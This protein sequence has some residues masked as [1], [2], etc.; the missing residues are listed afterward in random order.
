MT[1]RTELLFKPL[2]IASNLLRKVFGEWDWEPAPWMQALGARIR[3]RPWAWA[4]GTL[5]LLGVAYGA[6]WWVH[7][8]KPVDPEAI[9]FTVS[10]VNIT[11]YTQ[12]PPAV[13]PLTV[14]FSASVAPIALVDKP[15]TGISMDPALDGVWTWVGDRQLVFR[16]A[17]DWTVGQHYK[18][19]FD[20]IN[21]FAPKLR[22]AERQFEFDT[23]TFAATLNSSEFYQD[24]EDPKLKK[25]VYEIGFSHPVDVASFEQRVSLA[26][27]NGAGKKLTAPGIS[28][29]YDERKLKAYV[30]SQ[31]LEVPED[32]G[33]LAMTVEPGSK[34]TLG[35]PAVDQPISAAV[36]LPSLYSVAVNEIAPTLVDNDRFE[37]E[38][39]LVF[40]FNNT[41]RD[42][43]VA[44]GI[45]VYEL[46]ETNPKLK[47]DQQTSP[48][49]WST[50]EV[51]AGVLKASTQ[52]KLIAVPTE[53]EYIETHSFRYQATA[54]RKLYVRV[55]R[56]LKSFGGFMLGK[57]YTQ[58]IE[59]PAYPELL[60]FVGDGAL[61]SLK[62]ERRVTVAARNVAGLKVEIARVLPDQLQHLVKYNNGSFGVPSLYN[63]SSDSIVERFRRRVA[64]NNSD[65][66]KTQYEGIDLGEF[67]R[68]DKH[69]VF[70]LSLYKDDPAQDDAEDAASEGE[71]EYY[72]GGD[73]A[74]DTRLVVLTDLGVLSKRALD[75]SR[76]VF[77]QS[78]SSGLPVSGADVAVVARNGEKLLSESTDADGSVSLPSLSG[79]RREKEPVMLAISNGGDLSFLPLDDSARQLDVSRFDVGGE[80]NAAD[81]GMLKAYLFS[82][83]GLY[84]PGDTVNLGMIVRAA[85]WDR[86]LAGVPLEILITDPRGTVAQRQRIA[87]GA[88]GF[89]S[90]SFATQDTSASGTWDASLY[91]IGEE[92]SRTRIGG[93]TVQ[94]REFLPDRLRVRASLSS[95]S[96][97][98]WVSPE[99]LTG[100][101]L[102]ENLFGTPAQDRRVTA[103]LTL[104]PAFPRFAAY[105]DHQFY[106]PMRAKEGYSEELSEAA[107]D[108]A[109]HAEFALDLSAYDRATYQLRFLAQ[110]FE[111]GAGRGVAAETGVL[112]SSNPY[113]IGI[114]AVDSLD[115]V[116]R[117]AARSLNLLALGPDA[118]PIAVPGLSIALI[119]RRYVSVLTKQDS[120]LYKYVSQQREDLRKLE[121][122]ALAA[123]GQDYR[124]S[125]DTPGDYVIEVRDAKETVLNRIAYS[126]AGEANL[127]RSLER[128]AELQLT[129]SKGDYRPGD[130]IE[131]S[132]RAP[133]VG[134]G[135]ITI[136]RDRVYAHRWFKTGTTSSV[137][138]ITVPEDFEGNGY[139][140]VQFLRD[141]GSAEIFMSPLSYGVA[142]FSVD[143]GARRHTLTLT[144]TPVVKPGNA[145]RF[146]VQTGEPARVAVFAVDEGILQVARYSLGDPLDY[147]FTKKML[148]VDTA[149]ILDLL[150]PEFSQ[151][152]GA[153]A[154]GGDAD[155][156]LAKHLNPFKRKGDKPA[157]YWSGVVDI[158]GSHDFDY[159][160]P[161]SFNGKLRVMAVAVS[162][163]RVG[164]AQTETL[165]RGDF[166]LS[167]NLPMQV[168]PGDEFDVSVGV[169]NTALDA[170]ARAMP[171]DVAL[172]LPASLSIVGAA[173]QSVQIAPGNETS[174]VFRVRAGEQLGAALLQFTASSGKYSAKRSSDLSLRP[175]IAYRHE[176]RVG[177]TGKREV[178][179][180]L[181]NMYDQLAQRRVAASVSPL[182]I[183]DG[184]TAYLDNYPHY[185]TEQLL[186][187]A[188]P[189]LVF[190][191]HPEFGSIA[192]RKPGD[193]LRAAIDV[194]R[195]RQSDG[196]GFGLWVATPDADAFASVYAALYLIEARERGLA[197]PDDLLNG[198]NDYL[199]QLAGDAAVNGLDGL[200]KRALAVYLLTRQGRITTNLLAT[201][202]EQL[203]RE[204]PKLYQDDAIAAF[205]ASSYQLLKQEKSARTLISGPLQRLNTPR[206]IKNWLRYYDYYDEGIASAWT[207]YLVS[208]HFPAQREKLSSDAIARLLEPVR[209]NRHNT[210]SSALTILALDTYAATGKFDAL[211]TLAVIGADKKQAAIGQA[212][213]MIM[214]GLFGGD[215][216]Q[217]V[218]EP[219][220]GAP[221]W[222]SI[223]QSGFDRKLPMA[224]Q[225]EGLELI[226]DYL[227]AEGKPISAMTVG[228]EIEVRLRLRALG[229][230]ARGS[231]AVVDLLPGGFDLVLQSG[232]PGADSSGGDEEDGGEAPAAAAA[233]AL[234]LPGST[235]VVEH[236]EPR[237]D[238]VVLY[239][240]AQGEVREYR[241][242]IKASSVGKFVIP[243]PYAESMYERDVYA[244]GGAAGSLTVES[245]K[246]A[247]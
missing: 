125:T 127:S 231:I 57:P 139:V 19:R 246:P 183:A 163:A 30:H 171:I 103:M 235:L 79:F 63:I 9:T 218:I 101:V 151:L 166:V 142:P 71:E 62:G 114:K 42:Q 138:T 159:V 43:D 136:E 202:Q 229:A 170:P 244:Q 22:F 98:G 112:V 33:T 87:L 25:G 197:V 7:R 5:A 117:G 69:G 157:V 158:D 106:D 99:E 55:E 86:A 102:V 129:L 205:L 196:G 230:N 184:L 123:G 194:L 217:I 54:G 12:T 203:D 215:A 118:K 189:A 107:T 58:V 145:A 228:D 31:P 45:S 225:S 188:I 153:A 20:V 224:T 133:Y 141:P 80:V 105:P 192:E 34:S 178:V 213:G 195:S 23:P 130:E 90:Y 111:P 16:P 164:I 154:P 52:L 200:R 232:S 124:L 206:E 89:E 193:R 241:Y 46:P 28:F 131:V 179:G 115:Y 236:V 160:V 156:A 6:N 67:F 181:R 61:L 2:R 83:R 134:A 11:D 85:D 162:A 113:L 207:V 191:A 172:K 233:P 59:V 221:A 41:L 187:Q 169:S 182:V 144:S 96:V 37:P 237:E 238:R 168:A 72:G 212:Q 137:Q 10:A 78:L 152:S 150:L 15:A 77:V 234:A 239:A 8:P 108:A 146:T 116:Q 135:L 88:V 97:A 32:G 44:R 64:L 120:G 247:Q 175:N 210:L 94:V 121:P 173:R 76:D 36:S 128:N 100:K 4:M 95:E 242:R 209:M 190:I 68:N 109:G 185:C 186:S 161:D 177:S 74:I 73:Y 214:Q 126:I 51:D 53:R 104:Q 220:A 167:P 35:G 70:L 17:S 81:A 132:L 75:G 21:A 65:P 222:Y 143:R 110:A 226:R 84:R 60:R 140:N 208:R 92:D 211:P 148:Q 174:V 24:P 66:T 47:P 155:G 199:T 26:L 201:V 180:D 119:E 56:G 223:S 93:T 149:Q 3:A 48:Y 122:L 14:D 176:L 219:Q 49:Y 18:V 50:E 243:P 245:P 13:S 240:T 216:T 27:S 147:F 198:L 40:S 165:V 82:D 1:A 39:V 38:Q 204:Q 91:L 227:D 29:S